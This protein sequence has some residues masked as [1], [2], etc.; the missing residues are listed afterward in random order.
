MIGIWQWIAIILTMCETGIPILLT[1]IFGRGLVVT[2]FQYV[3]QWLLSGLQVA[4][5]LLPAVGLGIL[6]RTMPVK[7]Q[8]PALLIG[9][10]LVAYIKVSVLGV[11]LFGVAAA[12]VYYKSKHRVT[13]HNTKAPTASIKGGNG[14]EISGDEQKA[15]QTQLAF[16]NTNGIMAPFVIGADLAIE[17]S[18]GVNSLPTVTGIKTSLMGPLAGIGDTLLLSTPGAIFGGIAASMA[19]KGNPVGV[20][21]WLVVM[22]AI[23]CLVIPLYKMGYNSG[24]KLVTT[25]RDELTSITDAI[26]VVGLMVVGALIPTVIN[27]TVKAKYVAG[28]LVVNGQ[29]VLDSILPGMIP[30]L[31]VLLVYWLLGKKRMTPVRI[32]LVVLVLSIALSA[33][34]FL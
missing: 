14:E 19:V 8:W 16:F 34:G 32:I 9:F 3:P 28:K 6:L 20:I 21:L 17:E 24:A 1:V 18:Q 13:T 10:L 2:A 22:V 29:H 27:A 31:L 15:L 5:G 26:S 33:I 23:K 12:F 25:L 4:G 7:K 30:V 11:G